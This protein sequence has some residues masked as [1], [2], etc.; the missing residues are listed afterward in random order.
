MG[1]IL[2]LVALVINAITYI[3]CISRLLEMSARGCFLP[4]AI[5]MMSD[6]GWRGAGGRYIRKYIAVCAQGAVLVVAGTMISYGMSVAGSSMIGQLSSCGSISSF[7]GYLVL[8]IAI[9][10]AGVSMLFK[11]IGI[12][13][14]AFGG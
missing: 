14:D 9:A 12:V 7:L 6:D 13:N 5:A 2:R 8:F 4:I 10:I 3:V 11:S 1:S